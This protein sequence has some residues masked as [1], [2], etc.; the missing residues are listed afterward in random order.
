MV[1]DSSAKFNGLC[2]N[3]VMMTGPDLTNSLLGV[4]LRFRKEAIAI[5]AD[6]E[7]MFY[8]FRVKKSH[9]NFLR[10]IWHADNDLSAPLV[11]YQMTVHVFGNS[12]S[13]SI[14][15]FALRRSVSQADQDVQDFVC[16]NFYVDDGLTSCTDTETAEDLMRRTQKAL[17]D[18][19]KLRLHKIVSNS[20]AVLQSFDL[21][22]LAKD[23][24]DLDLSSDSPP[25]QRCLG[26]SWDISTDNFIF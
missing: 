8:N 10:F 16:R 21:V 17:E 2:L 3:S 13:P 26:L 5:T 7:Q 24:K 12:P 19:G 22:D 15:T 6:V 20:R 1:F 4:L 25:I 11:D 23:L 18:G 14:A 9:R